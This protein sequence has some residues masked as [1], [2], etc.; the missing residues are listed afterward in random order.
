MLPKGIGNIGNLGN[1]MKQAMEMKA[2]VEELK[3]QMAQEVIEAGAG[4]GMVSITM[5]GKMEVLS[6]AIDPEVIDPSEPEMLGTLVQAAVNEGVHKVQE[7]LQ[8]RMREAT[9]G[10]DIPG[11]T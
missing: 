1:M 8:E 2:K 7:L 3:E 4:G 10:L 11:L 9:G 5:N 6:V